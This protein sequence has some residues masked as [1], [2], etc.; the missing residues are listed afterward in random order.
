[1]TISA[2]V[3]RQFGRSQLSGG[4]VL[5]CLVG[6]PGEAA[7]APSRLAGANIARQVA[8]V[9]IEDLLIARWVTKYLNSSA[10]RTVLLA[11]VVGSAQQV[12]N[13]VDLKKTPVPVL[14]RE[15]LGALVDLLESQDRA[16]QATEDLLSAKREQKRGLMQEILTGRR[17]FPG[18]EGDWK[19]V[20][21]GDVAHIKTGAKDNQDK[22]ADGKY[23]FF[24]RSKEVERIDTFSYD[25]EAI[26]VPGEGGIGS[27]FHYICGP[28]EAH[29]RVYVI[30][31]FA[32]SISGKYIHY[33]MQQ[34][35]A[36]HAMRNSLKAA[37][38][39]LRLPTFKAF[40]FSCPTS[41][42][43]QEKVVHV[44]S[45]LDTEITYLQFLADQLR[46]QKRGLMQRLFSGDLDL[47]KLSPATAT[48]VPA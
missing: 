46:E 37:V 2:S 25:R 48:D 38:D 39:S 6:Y 36:R 43:E 34:F 41:K 22:V 3:S 13:L 42:S 40:Q 31:D 4:E 26:L 9:A 30:S 45:A 7:I 1:M 18:F 35:F 28:F 27:I 19:M 14:P 11:P 24:V 29:Q 33:A 44:F 15:Q 8:L 17:R 20:A 12:I 32:H 23:P 47:S 21:L 16:V 10:G 5:V